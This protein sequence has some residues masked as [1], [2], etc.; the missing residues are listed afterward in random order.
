MAGADVITRMLLRETSPINPEFILEKNPDI[1]MI[2][3]SYW[4]R[5]QPLCV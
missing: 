2:M 3:G 1:I 4:P 5:N